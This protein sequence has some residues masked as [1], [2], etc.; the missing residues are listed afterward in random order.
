MT[1]KEIPGG[2]GHI[3]TGDDDIRRYQTLTRYHALRLEALGMRRRGRSMLS[4]CREVYGLKA[5]TAKKAI[6][7]WEPQLREA[8]ILTRP[9]APSQE[10]DRGEE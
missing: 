2:G 3:I 4:I 7:E 5:R 9:P 8:G 1:V 6:V 10:V